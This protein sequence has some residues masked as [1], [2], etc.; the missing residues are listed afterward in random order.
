MPLGFN[1]VAS[2]FGADDKSRATPVP[3]F[4][5]TRVLAAVYLPVNFKRQLG[6]RE[7]TQILTTGTHVLKHLLK[8]NCWFFI[9]LFDRL[10]V[11]VL[12]KPFNT[13]LLTRDGI[14]L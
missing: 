13:A 9:P 4:V 2:Y 11:K 8:R 5:V 6:H 10:T 14:R 3:L 7:G 1:Y 12:F